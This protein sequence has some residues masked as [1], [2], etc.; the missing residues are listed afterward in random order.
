MLNIDILGEARER[1]LDTAAD[2]KA[3]GAYAAEA[4]A[5]AEAAA[6]TVSSQF[7]HF[8]HS[9]AFHDDINTAIM[10]SRGAYAA[11]QDAFSVVE[12]VKTM[13]DAGAL[14]DNPTYCRIMVSA[15][16][17]ATRE[18]WHRGGEAHEAA[19]AAAKWME[20]GR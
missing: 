17:V 9:K 11:S 10:A 13:L 2:A 19:K 5:K 6:K 12:K 4:S 8:E 18:A 7:V 3:A 15:A 20:R 16:R 14:L 1:A